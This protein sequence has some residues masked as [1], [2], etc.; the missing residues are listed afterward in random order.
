MSTS[1]P[2]CSTPSFQAPA[3][4][5]PDLTP[6]ARPVAGRSDAYE[7][8]GASN[9]PEY[10]TPNLSGRHATAVQSL[11]HQA[12]TAH[13]VLDVGQLATVPSHT[14]I[15]STSRLMDG[16]VKY[17]LHQTDG[18]VRVSSGVDN[19]N[20]GPYA[21]FNTVDGSNYTAMTPDGSHYS[22]AKPDY[23]SGAPFFVQ[24]PQDGP[25]TATRLAIVDPQV[26][27]ALLNYT[28]P[29]VGN[30]GF[31]DPQEN[32]QATL[33]QKVG[34]FFD[35][36][37]TAASTIAEIPSIPSQLAHVGDNI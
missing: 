18:N 12:A 1:V 37:K 16:F 17:E 34:H 19:G 22:A 10:W 25:P 8:G 26:A 2:L 29:T 36:L 27:D 4:R 9:L 6:E 24:N 21:T 31:V 5:L 30:F 15:M 3:T 11:L 33:G 28:G 13:P 20:S 14:W 35:G 23:A 32:P 7:G